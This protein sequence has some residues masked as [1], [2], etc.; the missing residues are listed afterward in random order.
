MKLVWNQ[1]GD[2]RYEFGVDRAVFYPSNND[3]VAWNGLLS[4]EESSI[5]GD[6]ESYYY[7]GIKYLDTVNPRNY[8]SV[9]AA[10]S[11]PPLFRASEGERSPVPGFILTRQARAL[12]GLSYRTLIGGEVGYKVHIVY[13]ALAAPTKR[14][15]NTITATANAAVLTWKISAVPPVAPSYRP[16]AHYILDSRRMV[17]LALSGLE[18][19]LYGTASNAPRLPTLSELGFL[20]T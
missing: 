13:N 15:Y 17:P 5:G 1:S 2:N 12:F 3:G 8:S 19:I 11:V 20:S 16:S 4:V 10:Y 7:D 9:I 6:S 18:D 14:P